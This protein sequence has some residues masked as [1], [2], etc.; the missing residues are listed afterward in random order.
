MINGLTCVKN[1]HGGVEFVHAE[2]GAIAEKATG[3]QAKEELSYL[4]VCSMCGTPLG[5]WHTQA[6]REQELNAFAEKTKRE[7]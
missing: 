6:E 1:T 2:C 4:M 7:A 5:E 3:A